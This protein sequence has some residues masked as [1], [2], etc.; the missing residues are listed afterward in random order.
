MLADRFGAGWVFIIGSTGL[1]VS[2]WTFYHLLGAHPELLFPLYA[3]TGAF[4]GTIGAVPYVMVKAFP[5]VVRFS[6]LSFSYNLAYAIFGGLTPMIVT[7]LVKQSPM[8]PSWY[9]AALSV[10]GIGL[11]VFLLA[12][13]R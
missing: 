9:V 6:G 8:G 1:L 5:P 4:V 13:K 12:R 11:G 7:L 10:L 3:V 2:S